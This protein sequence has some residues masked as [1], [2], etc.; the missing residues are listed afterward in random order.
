MVRKD[1]SRTKAML[2]VQG[3]FPYETQFKEQ[4]QK[5]LFTMSFWAKEWIDILT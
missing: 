5:L 3:S 1:Y 4:F 2:G